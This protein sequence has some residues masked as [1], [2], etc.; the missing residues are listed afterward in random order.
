LFCK[1]EPLKYVLINDFCDHT[2]ITVTTQSL[3]RREALKRSK[4][5]SR[6]D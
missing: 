1:G 2:A 6:N 4:G 3:E 5:E